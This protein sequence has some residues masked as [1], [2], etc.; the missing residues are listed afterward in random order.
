MEACSG[1]MEG[2]RGH[3]GLRHRDQWRNRRRSRRRTRRLL[4]RRLVALNGRAGV[5]VHDRR[6]LR[7]RRQRRSGDRGNRGAGLQDHG[8]RGGRG[9]HGNRGQRSHRLPHRTEHRLRCARRRIELFHREQRDPGERGRWRVA[10]RLRA[11]RGHG[12]DHRPERRRRH[13]H[14]RSEQRA[15]CR[16]ELDIW[17]NAGASI[18][19]PHDCQE[20]APSG[21]PDR[22]LLGHLRADPGRGQHLGRPALLRGARRRHARSLPGVPLHRDRAA[23]GADM[24]ASAGTCSGSIVHDGGPGTQA[25]GKMVPVGS[26]ISLRHAVPLL[27]GLRRH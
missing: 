11:S 13:L 20:G 1:V 3:R 27:Q 21:I 18:T 2:P 12:L 7:D 5:V 24:G 19:M 25:E 4:E 6:R 26:P 16:R 23:D 17:G 10:V 8:Q 22:P 14:L 9:V 15:Q